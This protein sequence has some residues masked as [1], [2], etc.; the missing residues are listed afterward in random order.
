[1]RAGG[2]R[3]SRDEGTCRGR[4]EEGRGGM[5]RTCFKVEE[6][7]GGRGRTLQESRGGDMPQS[8]EKGDTWCVFEPLARERQPSFKGLWS[9]VS[10]GMIGG[11][12]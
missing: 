1:M 4:V 11:K 7:R 10:A 9:R 2:G 6:G 8:D 12:G 3:G 5:R